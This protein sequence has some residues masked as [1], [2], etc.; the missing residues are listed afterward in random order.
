MENNLPVERYPADWENNGRAAGPIRNRQMA[1]IANAL[2]AFPLGES[3]GTRNMIKLAQ[4]KGL[5]V[6]IVEQTL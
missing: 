1:E 3:R 5:L 2:I 6:R 4:E